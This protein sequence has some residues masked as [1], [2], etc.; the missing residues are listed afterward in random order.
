M[1]KYL[2]LII[3]IIL[4]TGCKT[5]HLPVFEPNEVL[6][7]G[8]IFWIADILPAWS[9]FVIACE[10]D[11]LS[12]DGSRDI[13]LYY[14]NTKGKVIWEKIIGNDG[15]EGA[16]CLSTAGENVALAGFCSPEGSNTRDAL[17]ILFD[18]RGEILWEKTYGG[19]RDDEACSIKVHE[20]RFTVLGDTKL[21]GPGVE[22]FW[23]LE[24]DSNGEM[25]WERFYG[26]NEFNR[27]EELL[28][29]EDGY[30]IAGTSF[31]DPSKKGV[32]LY[33]VS[34][35]GEI[36]WRSYIGADDASYALCSLQKQEDGFLALTAKEPLDDPSTPLP[37]SRACLIMI[38]QAGKIQWKKEYAELEMDWS[39]ATMIQGRNGFFI[40]GNASTIFTAALNKK[41]EVQWINKYYKKNG[42]YTVNS[43]IELENG[44]LL[45]GNKEIEGRRTLWLF[46]VD[47]EGNTQ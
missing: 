17:I 3:L 42:Y 25:L 34:T 47:M 43:L 21:R 14:I 40:A 41:F 44:Y 1:R 5:S 45:S 8:E 31:T 37:M 2:L 36:E 46:K 10:I 28:L 19:Q 30:I 4:F 32:L 12:V 24:L 26:E 27:G 35:S 22:S 39:Y 7:T 11:H 23:L 6:Y 18:R 33:K 16:H 13:L 15:F 20:N 9:G 29:L 38:D